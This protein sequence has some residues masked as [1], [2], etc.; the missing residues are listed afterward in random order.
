MFYSFQNVNS[1]QKCSFLQTG[2]RILQ[3][4]CSWKWRPYFC[5]ISCVEVF[6]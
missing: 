3:T 1:R 4:L 5:K 6:I 2:P